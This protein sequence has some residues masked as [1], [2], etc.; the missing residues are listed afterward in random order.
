MYRKYLA[1]RP[2]RRRVPV[3]RPVT[4]L[5]SCHLSS[6]HP[7]P[8][9]P[10]ISSSPNNIL[11]LHHETTSSS[12]TS[13]SLN[14]ED[15]TVLDIDD[16]RKKNSVS[17]NK[18]PSAQNL[19]AGNITETPR[20]VPSPVALERYDS[21][22]SL[23][24]FVNQSRTSDDNNQSNNTKRYSTAA[25]YAKPDTSLLFKRSRDTSLKSA[26]N[27]KHR[28]IKKLKL[29]IDSLGTTEQQAAIVEETLNLPSMKAVK[30]MAHLVN[31]QEQILMSK[32][33]KN[34]FRSLK[35]VSDKPRSR[36]RLNDD[37][38]V[39]QESLVTSIVSS[40]SINCAQSDQTLKSIQKY[41][42]D[43]SNFT[44]ST[45]RRALH[46]GIARRKDLTC[47]ETQ[48][49]WCVLSNRPV[50]KTLQ[51][52]LQEKLLN[53]VLC[54]EYVIP[55]PQKKDTILVYN[56]TTKK[57][58]PVTKLLLQ[59][60]VR[61]L[62]DDLIGPPP[63]GLKDVYHSKTNKLLI[64]ESTF[65]QLLPPQLRPMTMAQKEICGCECCITV[66]MLHQSLMQYKSSNRSLR[67]N[68]QLDMFFNKLNSGQDTTIN[69]H[70]RPTDVV[71][72]ITCS[73]CVENQYKWHCLLDRC[74]KCS[75]RNHHWYG[76]RQLKESAQMQGQ[77]IH[78][79]VYKIHTRCKVHGKLSSGSKTCPLC[80]QNS[81][82][83]DGLIISKKEL[84]KMQS[85]LNVFL[86]DYYFP[87]VHKFKYHMSLVQMLGKFQTKCW[88]KKAFEEHPTWFL[89]E[90]DYAERLKKEMNNEIQSD[91]F[92]HHATLSIEGCTMEHHRIKSSSNTYE[93]EMDFHS[94][95]S[96]DSDQNAAT[97]HIHM[98][99]ML[100]CYIENY[101]A[102]PENCTILDHTDGC[103]KQYRCGNALF[104]LTVL[105][106]KFRITIDRAIAAPGHGKSIID[107]LNAVDKTHLKQKMMISNAMSINCNERQMNAFNFT[108]TEENSFA[109]ECARLCR[110][111]HRQN[112]VLTGSN[113]VA[114]ASQSK[115]S[116]RY[117]HVH[118][119]KEHNNMQISKTTT[120][121]HT[122]QGVKSGIMYHHN[123]R[124]DPKLP[125]G[126]I[127]ARRIP[128]ACQAC[129][130]QLKL[131]WLPKQSFY[132]QPRYEGGNTKCM[133]WNI[134][135]GL[136]DWLLVDVVDTDPDNQHKE[137]MQ[138]IMDNSLLCNVMHV[139]NTVKI[140]GYGAFAT[141]D[142]SVKVGYYIVQWTSVPYY[143]H[144][145]ETLHTFDPPMLLNAGDVVCD[146]VY[147]NDV[148]FR[149]LCIHIQ[150]PQ[151]CLPKCC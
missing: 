113:Y 132:N 136:N 57:R 93:L 27:R 36:G 86:N 54:H 125:I 40:P 116:R 108:N 84:T 128:C 59:C 114:R 81:S 24:T 18:E 98:C 23:S 126:K 20:N 51:R 29:C 68:H 38:R 130:T 53:W 11:L 129:I 135:N 105:A 110:S 31:E 95:M 103:T 88:L 122:S 45:A 28:L 85:P 133:Y 112:G 5:T 141:H 67:S 89:T 150:M 139:A 76:L 121:W 4:S 96:E 10:S 64:S 138:S 107:G 71:Q 73:P 46:K 142:N 25:Q 118:N 77:V 145:D 94:H 90:M 72:L 13:T 1:R 42:M 48:T 22:P 101:G 14:S 16:R 9:S 15:C 49:T 17:D 70:T 117:Y 75:A 63:K 146:A 137:E 119:D 79:G 58:E 106:H 134:F 92:G 87:Q 151:I 8:S 39:Y 43:H 102:L 50:Y 82:E 21:F 65:R 60:S 74:S 2:K 3:T 80:Q 6:P 30:Q 12:Q 62:H 120:G 115:L 143:L 149:N 37:R 47:T 97:T 55:S 123:F 100:D 66:K 34:V 32:V 109:E 61:E 111:K 35:E 147:L 44:K 33:A 7:H 99:K 26:Y 124:A 78:F 69:F 41:M 104:Y 144:Q 83:K 131:P 56:P 52:S 127:A 140:D 19:N 91:H 148:F